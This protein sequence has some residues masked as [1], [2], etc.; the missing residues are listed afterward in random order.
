[1]TAMR[2]MK[3]L[4]NC[5]PASAPSR[6]SRVS[7]MADSEVASEAGDEESAMEMAT[8]MFTRI[9]A[10]TMNLMQRWPRFGGSTRGIGMMHLVAGSIWMEC[11]AGGVTYRS[12]LPQSQKSV[13]RASEPMSIA[14]AGAV[15]AM[16]GTR[17]LLVARMTELE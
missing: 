15:E 8:R 11:P 13:P 12:P 2:H 7:E 17:V 5:L 4:K 6:A 3:C 10:P 14:S 1:M 16:F 9:D